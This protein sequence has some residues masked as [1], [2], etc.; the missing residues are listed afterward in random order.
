MLHFTVLRYLPQRRKTKIHEWDKK[1]L[2][3]SS[4]DWNERRLLWAGQTHNYPSLTEPR[5]Q[6]DST[7]FQMN[8]SVSEFFLLS[9]T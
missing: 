5:K 6:M 9:E 1:G 8:L 3:L 2:N 4:G 7:Y